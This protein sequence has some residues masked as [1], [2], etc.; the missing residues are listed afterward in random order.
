MCIVFAGKTIGIEDAIDWETERRAGY[1]IARKTH[2]GAQ[3]GKLSFANRQTIENLKREGLSSRPRI[4]KSHFSW[5]RDREIE[6]PSP[7]T[8][9]GWDPRIR[10][11]V[12]RATQ[13]GKWTAQV[14]F[15]MQLHQQFQI[16]L[17]DP[18]HAC[19]LVSGPVFCF[20]NFLII[21]FNTSLTNSLLNSEKCIEDLCQS[22]QRKCP[23]CGT[24]FGRAD[25]KQVFLV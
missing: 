4:Q 22:R 9:C 20:I 12:W 7:E 21:F 2:Y 17:L 5:R 8:N 11:C 15:E 13:E 10:K 16:A 14:L 23:S 24:A 18:M 1:N 3:D 19:F 6:G 25:V